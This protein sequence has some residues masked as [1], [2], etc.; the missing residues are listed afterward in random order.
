[1][2]K[3]ILNISFILLLSVTIYGQQ[4]PL[5]NQ[6]LINKSLLTP[7][8]SGINGNIESFLTYRQNWVG[9]QGAP[10]AGFLNVNG[11]F[12]DAM[13]FGFSAITQKSG[14]FSQNFITLSYAY[15]LYINDNMA[16]SAGISPLFYRNSLNLSTIQSYGLQM[17]PLLLN[18]E[19]LGINAFDVG[20]S[21]AFTY[22]NFNAGISVPQTIGMTFKFDESG[23]NFGLKRHYFGF[24]SYNIQANAFGIEPMAI[25]RS[26]EKSP[27][28][29]SGNVRVNYKNKLWSSVGYSADQSVLISVGVLSSNNLA[30]NYSYEVGVAGLSRAGSGT[31]EITIGFLIKPAKKFKQ[32]AT[33]FTPA[34]SGNIIEPIDNNLANK[35]AL[36]EAQLKRQQ[37]E[38]LESDMELQRQIDSIKAILANKQVVTQNNNPDVT[39]TVHWKQRVVSQNITFGL[40]NDKIFSSSFSELDKYAQKLRSNSD[41]KIKILVY[42]DNLFSEQ[43]NKQLSQSRA[44]SVANY[45]LSKPGIKA[46]QIEYEGMGAVDPIGDNTTPEGREKNNR[47]E[48][49]FSETIF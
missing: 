39:P 21:L 3:K 7:A 17:D 35:V 25:V 6:H 28:N 20:V 34:E 8:L 13:G 12:N 48:F 46:S 33:V 4:I 10:I 40:M 41:L 26:T 43:V 30:I 49:L 36:L 44:K 31:H 19:A 42:T 1:M 27:V 11:A 5:N 9:V 16:I 45:L 23:S 47:V 22:A 2:I 14:N 37:Q 38:G 24:M 32:N 18:N 29:Y 15:H